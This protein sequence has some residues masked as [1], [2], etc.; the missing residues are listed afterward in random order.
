[1]LTS[2]LFKQLE[3][4]ALM[5]LKMSD[6]KRDVLCL[7]LEYSQLLKKQHSK[8]KRRINLS[9]FFNLRAEDRIF[10]IDFDDADD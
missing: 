9:Q 5:E 6:G 2:N 3:N 7:S 4:A 8:M 1:M 10:M